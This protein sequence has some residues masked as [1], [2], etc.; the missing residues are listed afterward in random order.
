MGVIYGY[1]RMSTEDQEL[2]LR[3]SALRASRSQ[4]RRSA[5]VRH[6]GAELD[7]GAARREP[8]I[9]ESSGRYAP[10]SMLPRSAPCRVPGLAI[11]LAVWSFNM[12]GEGLRGA[13]D[14]REV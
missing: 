11:L 6:R 3:I 2:G 9:P 5:P 14:P 8:W 12:L 4:R 10:R 1:A 7:V 13:L